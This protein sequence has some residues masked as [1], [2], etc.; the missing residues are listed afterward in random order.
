[1]TYLKSSFLPHFN[2]HNL[3]L[4]TQQPRQFKQNQLTRKT[5]GKIFLISVYCALYK[6]IWENRSLHH[7]L[8]RTSIE[9]DTSICL[10]SRH[11]GS[12]DQSFLVCGKSLRHIPLTL[13]PGERTGNYK[14][15]NFALKRIFG[16][17]LLL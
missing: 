17:N 10:L 8:T 15:G 16:I 2:E 6:V 4:F 7:L 14:T 13:I 9:H 5:T 1:M 3:Q 11:I 12:K